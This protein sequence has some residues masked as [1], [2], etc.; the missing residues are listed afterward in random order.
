[1]RE[2]LVNREY[3]HFKGN[4]YKVIC[5]AMH[6]ETKEKLVVYQAMYGEYKYFVRPYDMFI[7]RVDKIKYPDISQEYIFELIEK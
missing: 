4:T 3:R 1:M 7:A 2:I 5:I 6:T